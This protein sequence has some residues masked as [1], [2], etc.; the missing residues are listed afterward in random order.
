MGFFVGSSDNKISKSVNILKH[1]EFD[2]QCVPPKV[3][4]D[5]H[6]DAFNLKCCT[7]DSNDEI[8]L[9]ELHELCG[10]VTEN[11]SGGDSSNLY[12]LQVVPRKNKTSSKKKN[13]AN[14]SNLKMKGI[15]FGSVMG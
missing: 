1:M 5:Q 11:F 8:N 14:N 7:D 13:K 9:L 4:V 12:D 6:K 3:A 2:R 10:D 15:F